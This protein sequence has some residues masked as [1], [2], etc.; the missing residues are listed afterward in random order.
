[1]AIKFSRISGAVSVLA[2]IIGASAAATPSAS[3]YNFT[4]ARDGQCGMGEI[5]FYYNSDQQGSV[6]DF[7]AT[8]GDIADY[9][10]S[11]PGCYDFKGD[12]DGKGL[13]MK[14]HAASVGNFSRYPV[15]IYFN[16]D[17][18]GHS[19]TIP[20]FSNANLDEK[21]KNNNASHKVG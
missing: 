11:Q 19:Q 20:P 18:G 21:L 2:L 8:T 15:T 14:N 5:C 12:G 3:A 17:F 6:S 4:V 9:G 7:D 16:S 1:M 10:T 13:C